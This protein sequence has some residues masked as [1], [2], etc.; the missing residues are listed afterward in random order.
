MPLRLKYQY[1]RT[2]FEFLLVIILFYYV[3]YERSQSA[4]VESHW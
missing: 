2:Y 1:I 4:N 3:F